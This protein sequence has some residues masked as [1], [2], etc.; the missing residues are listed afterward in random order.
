MNK[1]LFGLPLNNAI[2][3]PLTQGIGID[4]KLP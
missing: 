2:F 1:G 4:F 3:A